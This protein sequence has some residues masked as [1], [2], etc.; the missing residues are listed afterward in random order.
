MT[1][2]QTCALPIS[3]H[4]QAIKHILRY[5]Q[6]TLD[7]GL[8]LLSQS[9]LS[10]YGFSEAN[11]AGCPNTRHSTT[12]YCIYLGI[13]CISWASKEQATISRS[14]AEAEYRSMSSTTTELTW[15]MY[16]LRDIG[17]HLS[18]PPVLFYDNTS[19][20]H[21]IV[22]SFFHART[23]HI[24]LD[25]HFVHEKVAA[26]ALVSRFVPSHLQFANIFTKALSKTSFHGLR[27]K[28]GVVPPPPSSLRGSDKSN[29]S[30]AKV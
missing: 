15:I 25:V 2:V 17:L 30:L 18:A 20:L 6:G 24:E 19:A 27:I 22:N 26:S 29:K 1:G 23:K 12:S 7:Y 8:R 4:F 5:L 3:S 11:W 9:S 16:L 28:I 21:M 13:N 10:L 14:S